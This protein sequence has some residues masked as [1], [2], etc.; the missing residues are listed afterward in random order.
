MAGWFIWRENGA[1][2]PLSNEDLAV[3]VKRGEVERR[4]WLWHERLGAWT[5]ASRLDFL[6]PGDAGDTHAGNDGDGRVPRAAGNGQ[7]RRRRTEAPSLTALYLKRIGRQRGHEPL[8]VPEQLVDGVGDDGALYAD[9]P[10]GE[11]NE[12]R[13]GPEDA[14]AGGYLWRPQDGEGHAGTA[15]AGP[16]PLPAG[17]N[18]T[19]AGKPR[20]K[21]LPP[22]PLPGR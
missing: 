6:W 19:G 18:V 16:P 7:Q 12:Q 15:H 20:G 17:P 14:G 9:S 8:V 11:A 5:E 21:P 4:D 3:R 2:G 1:D 22:P 10:A 13:Q